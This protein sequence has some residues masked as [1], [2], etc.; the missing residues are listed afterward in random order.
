MHLAKVPNGSERALQGHNARTLDN[1][2]NANINGSR[3]GLNYN[4]TDGDAMERFHARLEQCSYRKQKNNVRLEE[5]VLTAPKNVTEQDMGRFFKT[6][7]R[8]LQ[9][10]TGGAN[11][12]VSAWV[13]MDETTPH[14][15][16]DFVPAVMVD[17]TLKLSAK[18]LMDRDKLK[19]LHT[20]VQRAINTEFG[21]SNYKVVADNSAERMQASDTL[22]AYKSKM[23]ELDKLDKDIDTAEQALS[24]L[25]Q[26]ISDASAERDSVQRE[27]DATRRH[28]ADVNEELRENQDRLD[29]YNFY[30]YVTGTLEN[31]YPDYF[32]GIRQDWQRELQEQHERAEQ[33][34]S[35]M[36]L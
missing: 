32:E 35:D 34:Y 14:M 9:G 20:V 16:L 28:L 15:H 4:L 10:L 23:A 26:D 8:A 30:A 27:I 3:T 2:S 6:A 17:G 33:Y 12:V 36:E 7:Y 21:H 24:E 18:T 1:H 19:V 25:E 22:Q 5:I 29:E 11:N 31:E 13:H